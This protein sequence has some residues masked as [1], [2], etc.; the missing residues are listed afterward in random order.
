M[1]QKEQE[2]WLDLLSI[3]HHPTPYILTDLNRVRDNLRTLQHL[4]PR[5]SMF[6]AIKSRSDREIIEAIDDVVEGYDIASLGEY[7]YLRSLGV[8]PGRILYSNPVKVPD[9]ITSTYH[10]G[11]RYYAFDSLEELKKIS[12]YAPDSNI[13]LR[14]KV[15]DYGSRFPLSSKFGVDKLHA[16]AYADTAREMGLNMM[17]I[18]FHV[19]SQ[20]ENPHTWE[21][22]FEA[23][24]DTIRRL[25]AAGIHIRMLNIGGGFPSVYTEKIASIKEIA[26]A[27]NEAIDKYIPENID[28]VAEP[29]RYVV[30]DSS[31]IASSV[32]GREHRGNSEWLFLDM[33][34]FQGLMETLEMEGWR[35]PVFTKYGKRASD[36]SR[37]FVLTGPTCDAYDTI[38]MHYQ[39]PSD[40]KVGDR[41]YIGMTG[42]YTTV[43]QSYFNGF[44]PPKPYFIPLREEQ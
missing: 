19:G 14:I 8:L 7:E 36:F 25:T 11:V 27:I 3:H 21:A 30:A 4:L 42:A 28:I 2:Q 13:Y 29:G 5:V 10:D 41:I 17:G 38:G 40:I 12:D 31:V 32:I 26:K 16:V 37:P 23:A 15:S 22:A 20:S 9:H 43:Y 34:V 39:L 35:Y 6:Y 1:L 24:G 18:A 44:E 33:G